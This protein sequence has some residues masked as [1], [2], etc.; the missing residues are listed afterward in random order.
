MPRRTAAAPSYPPAAVGASSTAPSAPAGRSISVRQQDLAPQPVVDD[1]AGREQVA[2]DQG[3]DS[4]H[5]DVDPDGRDGLPR[6]SVLPGV[7]AET[8][9][10]LVGRPGGRLL[11]R[12]RGSD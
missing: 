12:A 8:H 10:D 3:L 11:A 9:L 1:Q 5:D 6:G 7:A 4:G 2:P